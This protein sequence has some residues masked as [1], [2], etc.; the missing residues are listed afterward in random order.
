MPS[1]TVSINSLDIL[2]YL[3]DRA[4]NA[5]ADNADAVAI[6]AHSKGISWRDGRLEDT[7]SS[8]IEDI[9]L[10]VMI[11]QKQAIVST[12]NRS[13]DNLN[14]LVSRTIEMAKAVPEDE[15]CGLAPEDALH[16][17]DFADLDLYDDTTVSVSKLAEL[18][19][20]AETAAR[21]V[22]GVT[23]S[24][25]A[26]ASA[27]RYGITL[28][29]SHGFTGYSRG[30][31]FSVSVSAIAGEGTGMERDYDF[32][33]ARHFS[34]L[35]DPQIVG[36][37]AGGRAATRLNP[38]KIESGTK[39]IVFAPRVSN[40][41]LGHFS[42]AINGSSIARGTSFLKDMLNEEIFGKEIS[43][44]DDPLMTRGLK[45]RL[46][47]GEGVKVRKC[48]LVENGTL[49]TWMLNSATAKQLGL[50]VTGHASRSSTSTPGITTSNLYMAPGSISPQDLIADIQDGIYVTEL[51]GMGVNPVTGDYSRGA[52]G[53][54]IKDGQIADSVSEITIAGNLKE[55][56]KT[57]VPASDLSFTYGSNA[58]TVRID[59]MMI[60]GA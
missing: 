39:P 33:S 6:D 5:G 55:M 54:L 52:A 44:I 46:F 7:D 17:G 59:G 8:E 18:A 50:E 11:G 37:T 4:L 20:T 9:G 53:F 42:G 35:K 58:P 31:S 15:Y 45:S 12:S 1:D 43:I 51:I 29:T 19:A 60:A 40:T 22:S 28:L 38:I 41:L 24:D 36:Q 48:N 30:S 2:E 34:D 16:K 23:N 10:R 3:V 57:L 13:S 49:K 56:F 32:T 26:S 27:S 21:S 25:G 14:E 47:D